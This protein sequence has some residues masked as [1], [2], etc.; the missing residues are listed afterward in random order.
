MSVASAAQ[1]A[2]LGMTA[3]ANSFSPQAAGQHGRKREG[4]AEASI[5]HGAGH[6]H[7]DYRL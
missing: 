3:Q 5:G 1:W 7:R 2:V 4:G 6:S